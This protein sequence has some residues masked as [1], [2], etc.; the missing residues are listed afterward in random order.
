MGRSEC[1]PR[2]LANL[3]E[4]K[5]CTLSELSRHTQIP[6]A[7]LRGYLNGSRDTI[8]TRNFL[9]IAQ[10]FQ[11]PMSELMDQL[12]GLNADHVENDDKDGRGFSSK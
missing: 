2:R 3:L 9:L 10:Y 4:A 8:S 6:V 1:S 5:K 11:M 12:S 7:T